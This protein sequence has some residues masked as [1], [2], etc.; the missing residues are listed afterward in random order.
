M[1]LFFFIAILSLKMWSWTKVQNRFWDSFW[2]HG[3]ALLQTYDTC[4]LPVA[5]KK[6]SKQTFTKFVIDNE[7]SGLLWFQFAIM[8]TPMESWTS[9]VFHRYHTRSQCSVSIRL[10]YPLYNDNKIQG[11]KLLS[12]AGKHGNNLWC[13]WTPNTISSVSDRQRSCYC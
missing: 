8:C 13:M 7:Y 2:N 3:C 10:Q 4:V 11:L 1:E 6:A 9:M 12:K 5:D